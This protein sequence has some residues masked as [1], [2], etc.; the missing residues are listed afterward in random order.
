MFEFQRRTHVYETDLMGIVHHSNYLRFFEEARVAWC[1]EK[2]I[3][4]NSKR[5]VFGLTVIETRVRHIAPIRFG[6]LLQI[7]VQAKAE[8]VR[9]IFQ[10]R[11]VV[12]GKEVSVGETV[13]CRIDEKF[14]VLR[15]DSEMTQ[16]LKEEKW[17][18]IL[19]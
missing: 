5:S 9:M 17:T 12:D 3:I 19:R 4:D 8:G 13:H 16:L 6:D 2:K 1:V 7:F 14:K 10:Y 11:L 15:L 18:E